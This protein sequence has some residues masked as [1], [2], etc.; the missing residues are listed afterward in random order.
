MNF[1]NQLSIH[2]KPTKSIFNNLVCRE[3]VDIILLNKLINSNLLL[4]TCHGPNAKIY[5]SERDLLI[6]YASRVKDSHAQILYTKQ[7][8]HIGRCMAQNGLSYLG[9]RREIRHTLATEMVDIDIDNCHPVCMLQMLKHYKYKS[10]YLTDYVNNRNTW[11]QLIRKHM[12]ITRDFV[13]N[14]LIKSGIEHPTDEQIISSLKDI[15]KALML[16]LMYNGSFRKWVIDFGLDQNIPIPS[17]LSKFITEFAEISEIFMKHN[18]TIV[19]QVTES[20]IKGQSNK[21]RQ[22]YQCI[23]RSMFNCYAS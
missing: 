12:N 23:G 21:R 8:K 22:S 3:P 9:I 6:K 17:K 7:L 4:K 13:T 15:P 18:K 14:K 5:E 16:R 19:K 20:N 11:F 2:I 10:I 1:K